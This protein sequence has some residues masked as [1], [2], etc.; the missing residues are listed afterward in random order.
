[1]YRYML[2]GGREGRKEEGGRAVCRGGEGDAIHSW[3][4]DIHIYI[5]T[6]ALRTEQLCSRAASSAAE[7]LTGV[8]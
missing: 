3:L 8:S 6:G 5:Q 1:M 2:W 4:R 7:D